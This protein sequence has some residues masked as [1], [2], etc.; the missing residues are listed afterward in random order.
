MPC[1]DGRD[2][3]VVRLLIRESVIAIVDAIMPF[4]GIP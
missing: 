2:H 1:Q 3:R 4:P